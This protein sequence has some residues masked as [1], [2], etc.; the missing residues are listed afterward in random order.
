MG[1]S[2]KI[3]RPQTANETPFYKQQKSE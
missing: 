1:Q 3:K 2:S